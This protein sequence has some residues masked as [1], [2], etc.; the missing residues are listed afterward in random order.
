MDRLAVK[1]SLPPEYFVLDVQEVG[2]TVGYWRGRPIAD[3]VT[4]RTGHRYVYR[5]LA[6]RRPDG[7][8]DIE[9]LQGG[10]WI[11]APGLLYAGEPD[12]P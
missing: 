11:V 5:G 6:P 3:S 12:L 7:S 8:L 2:R 4:D 1:R 10:E 9:A